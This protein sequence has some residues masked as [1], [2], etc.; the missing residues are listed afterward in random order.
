MSPKSLEDA[1]LE[2]AGRHHLKWLHEVHGCQRHKNP[3]ES[4]VQA[5]KTCKRTGIHKKRM[6]VSQRPLI[7]V[8]RTAS[9]LNSE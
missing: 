3:D 5:D 1:S 4:H 6:I 8:V 9:Q 2:D 7:A